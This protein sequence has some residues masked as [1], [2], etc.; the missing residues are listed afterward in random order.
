V[1]RGGRPRGE[2][3]FHLIALVVVASIV[4]HSSTDT[5]VAHA[6]RRA[7]ARDDTAG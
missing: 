5:L 6:L 7:E 1:H 4:A 3:R 2:Q